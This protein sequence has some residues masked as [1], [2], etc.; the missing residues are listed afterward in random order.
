MS[1]SSHNPRDALDSLIKVDRLCCEFESLRLPRTPA[2]VRRLVDQVPSAELRLALLTELMRIEFEARSK[3]GLVTSGV[4]DS[5]RFRHE[6]AGHVSVDL[7]DRD[8]AIAEFSARQR[9]GDQPSVDDFCAWTQNS[10][11]AFALSLHQQ[12]EI[13]FPLRVTFFEDDRKIAACDFSRPIEFGRRQQR[14]PAANG[15]TRRRIT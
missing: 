7:V 1:P 13:L 9:W 2:D 10:D 12:L 14:D 15:E 11:P 3:Q 6:L 4:A 5:L 8:L